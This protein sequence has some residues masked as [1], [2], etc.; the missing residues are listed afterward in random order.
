MSVRIRVRE[1]GKE[2]S[3][4][5]GNERGGGVIAVDGKESGKGEGDRDRGDGK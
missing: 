1:K 4:T 3:A 5:E 2:E